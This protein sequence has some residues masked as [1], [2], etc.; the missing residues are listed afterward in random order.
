MFCTTWILLL[1]TCTISPTLPQIAANWEK[2]NPQ[3]L[4][5]DGTRN[6][7]SPTCLEAG[8]QSLLSFSEQQQKTLGEGDSLGSWHR[9]MGEIEIRLYLWVS[10]SQFWGVCGKKWEIL[11]RGEK[12]TSFSVILHQ[13][14]TQT[15]GMVPLPPHSH[16][17][18]SQFPLPH[19]HKD[20]PPLLFLL[21]LKHL[22]L[23]KNSNFLHADTSF[24]AQIRRGITP[25]FWV[26]T[27]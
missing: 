18:P 25:N 26:S 21:V 22:T 12:E 23:C 17:H 16:P 2:Q 3:S 13:A 7:G 19:K 8:I 20:P 11:G 9:I 27:S 6:V 14:L 24:T 10:M 4:V 5:T 15:T 1:I